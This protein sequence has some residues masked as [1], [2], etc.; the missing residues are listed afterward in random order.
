MANTKITELTA[1][2]ALAATDV[3]PVVDV[4]A[5]TTKKVS[6]KNLLRNAPDG[7][8]GAPSIANAGDQDTGIYFPAA[9][10]VGVSTD[11]TQRLVID[12]SGRVLVGTASGFDSSASA[13]LQLKPPVNTTPVLAL[14]RNDSTITNDNNLG[15]IAFY[16]LHDDVTV[17]GARIS[18]FASQD[19]SA[20][21]RGTDLAFA[22]TAEDTA[23]NP[24]ERM[25]LDS[26]GRLLIGTSI[27][28]SGGNS[29]AQNAPLLVQGRIGSDA[30]SGRINLQRGSAA[31]NGSSIGTISFTDNS[32]N[33][34][35][36]LEVEA[37]G[38]TGSGNYPG[39][40]KFL[41]TANGASS[42]TERVRIDR[43]GAVKIGG[44]LPSSPNI[45]LQ[46]N[47]NYEGKGQISISP[48]GIASTIFQAIDNGSV[49]YTIS[50]DG[51]VRQKGSVVSSSTNAE[52]DTLY[53]GGSLLGDYGGLQAI[54]PQGTTSL[55]TKDVFI[56]GHG[57]THTSKIFADGSATFSGKLHVQPGSSGGATASGG[58]DDLIVENSTNT[59]I[60]ILTADGNKT[61]SLFFGNATDSLGAA[62]R[63]NHD[64]NQMQIGPDKAGAH[65]RFNSGDGAEAAR[66][67]SSKRLLVG[68]TSTSAASTLLLENNSLGTSRQGILLLARGE[69][70]PS[71]GDALGTFVF[72]AGNHDPAVEI[73][74]RRDGGTWTAGSSQPTRL[75]FSTAANSSASPTERLRISSSGRVG[76]GATDVNAPLEVR[77]SSA[78]QIRTSTG[79]G[80]YWEFGRDSST[81]D[82]FL[83]DDG[84]GT[85]V[86]VD[87]VTGAVG[88]GTATPAFTEGNGLRIEDASRAT[89]RLQDTGAHG[90][91]ISASSD[92]AKFRTMNNK[93]F[94]F[95]N[96]SNTE[97]LRI[98]GTGIAFNGDTAGA[99]KLNDYEEG[100]FT[101]EFA[102]A[103]TAGT[104][105]YGSR[106]GHYT[107][108]GDM[109][110]VTIVLS[111]INT[112]TAGTGDINITGLPFTSANNSSFAC[113]SV[114][115]DQF[116]VSGST[117][118]LAVRNT[119]NTAI[120]AIHEIRD[121]LTDDIMEVGG[122]LTNF[123]DILC[124]ITYR[125]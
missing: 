107:K 13:I 33:A 105:T 75:E 43:D 39:R 115:L 73:N 1:V 90:F 8:A 55:N 54:R 116:N 67:D 62:V 45:I 2:T 110:N 5:S 118:S 4:S 111:N 9:N 93:R 103:T 70:T 51:S 85:V 15:Q 46:A 119:P 34:Y 32:N 19:H 78:L 27:S 102:G 63:W 17:K 108:I 87:Q 10:S 16:S 12:N 91:E 64:S 6:V 80:N 60:S 124:T 20:T 38:S 112:S 77:N 66:I 35:A 3:F 42:P 52:E 61:T 79:T 113:G 92:E 99:N 83:A 122:K 24:T 123:A 97:L 22:T 125:V 82:F 28:P 121:S 69:A 25:R 88:I 53:I 37:D 94:V 65:L 86:A 48:A 21:A 44:T 18:A 47:G 109:V 95:A 104:Y 14:A 59:G 40:I 30:D 89:L 58:A 74:A 76:I 49:T 29:H 11:G 114:I 41:T 36:R 7:S 100:T 71:N 84:L 81:G 56:G 101:P 117:R 106:T 68:Q 50:R 120:L 23:G 26:S 57:N 72:T 96:S 98:T 31:S